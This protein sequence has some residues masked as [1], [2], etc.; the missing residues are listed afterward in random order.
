MNPYLLTI[1]QWLPSY[2]ASHDGFMEMINS[3]VV[4]RK[5]TLKVL[6]NICA[7][8]LRKSGTS[9]SDELLG[10]V[11]NTIGVLLESLADSATPVCC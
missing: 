6:R 8:V 2:S 7:I 1:F 4:A 3:S 10:I 5:T 9:T 11:E